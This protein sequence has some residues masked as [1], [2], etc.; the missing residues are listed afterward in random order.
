[1]ATAAIPDQVRDP[2]VEPVGGLTRT[3]AARLDTIDALRGLVIAIMVLDHVRDY[4]HLGALHFDPTDPLRTTPMLFATRW[5]THLCATTFV[6]L[7]GVSIYLQRANGKP[8][9]ELSRFVLSR[10]LWLIFLEFTVVSFAFNFGWPFAFVQVIWAIGFGMVAMAALAWLSPRAVLAIGVAIVALSPLTSTAADGPLIKAG[11]EAGTEAAALAWALLMSPGVL[12]DGHIMVVYAAVPWLGVMCLGFGLGPL[13]LMPA[14]QRRR[15]V[16]LLAVLL[17]GIFAVLRGLND[18]GDPA[19][20]KSL[21]TPTQTVMSFFNLSKYPPSPVF[22]CAT[23]GCSML[24]FLAL[25]RLRGPAHRVLL[26]FGRTPLMTYV[27]HIFIAHGL[28]LATAAALGRPE[29]AIDVVHRSV[30]GAF[31]ADWGFSLPVVY[32]VWALVV[33][34]LIPLA[35]WFAGVKRRRRDWWLGYL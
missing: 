10:G 30:I 29:V 12:A 23:L 4:F 1:M 15:A 6:F 17:L 28:M 3:G 16:L 11:A 8:P 18:Y 35:R 24:L 31:P 19:P 5:I 22:V 13:F 20:W 27:A 21:A 2:L 7:S 34:M 25:E 32:A 9:A 26:D 33:A 14:D